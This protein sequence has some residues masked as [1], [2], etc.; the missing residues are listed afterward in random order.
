MNDIQQLCYDLFFPRRCPFCGEVIGFLPTCL[1]CEA[2]VEKHLHQPYRLAATE[3][4][5][6]HLE[7][8]AS[9]FLFEDK[10]AEAIRQ[11]KY[12][13]KPWYG[14]E[15]G[16]IMAQRLFGCTFKVRY[17]IIGMHLDML[18][19]PQYDLVVPIPP[20]NKIR[21]F[22]S[23]D[24]IAQSLAKSIEVP[25]CGGNLIKHRQTEP[26]A[27][28]DAKQRLY[29]VVGSMSVREPQTIEGK[30]ILLVDDVITT[31]ATVTEAA[32]ALMR[33]GAHSVFAVSAAASEIRKPQTLV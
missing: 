13:A 17:G 9:V 26:Q 11:M 14:R 22:S 6:G 29:N 4:S 19:K 3:H 32:G 16:Y 25:F 12:G 18:P 8:A 2:E 31:G 27:S 5:L 23:T 21:G 30:R 20:S 33:A 28:L 10:P 1:D 7:G 24:R 15:L